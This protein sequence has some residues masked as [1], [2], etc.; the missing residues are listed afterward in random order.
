MSPAEHPPEVA[1]RAEEHEVAPAVAVSLQ[2]GRIRESSHTRG[3]PQRRQGHM[4]DARR[5]RP[6]RARGP[7]ARG[8]P[9][10][11]P[12]STASAGSR[13]G[14]ETRTGHRDRGTPGPDAPCEVL[15]GVPR[16]GLSVAVVVTEVVGLP[17]QGGEDDRHALAPDTPRRDDKGRETDSAV[18]RI[19]AREVQP[20]RPAPNGNRKRLP[21]RRRP[22]CFARVT[23]NAV[24]LS[25]RSTW[26]PS[27]PVLEHL[28]G[29]E[30]CAIADQEPRTL[31]RAV[32]LSPECCFHGRDEPRVPR[33]SSLRH[34]RDLARPRGPV[35]RVSAATSP[36]ARHVQPCVE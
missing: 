2:R 28:K 33:G 13:G 10:A 30:P 6:G 11:C 31:S 18:R 5:P 8:R 16:V 1:V 25:C 26:C 35:T 29:Q 34:G 21:A 3:G 9:P 19:E 14:Y 17:G 4:H 22:I 15:P 12:S 23:G 32:A 24:Q 27:R 20:A 7:T 36:T